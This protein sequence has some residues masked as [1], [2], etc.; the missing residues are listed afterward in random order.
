MNLPV[1]LD[2]VSDSVSHTFSLRI[3]F[4]TQA[5]METTAKKFGDADFSFQ[6]AS[7]ENHYFTNNGT[8][9]HFYSF[10]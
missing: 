8:E 2:S 7:I 9:K 3:S 10:L 5:P 4:P 1:P 6:F